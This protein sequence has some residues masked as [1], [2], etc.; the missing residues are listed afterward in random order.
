MELHHRFPRRTD[1][2]DDNDDKLQCALTAIT[3]VA[4]WWLLH[5]GHRKCTNIFIHQLSLKVSKYKVAQI[6]EWYRIVS[7]RSVCT[8]NACTYKHKCNNNGKRYDTLLIDFQFVLC[9]TYVRL[10]S[11]YPRFP[12]SVSFGHILHHALCLLA[13]FSN[14]AD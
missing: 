13:C 14:Q 5:L 6:Q 12:S 10:E 2:A 8:R 3:I 4:L 7:I 9:S 11:P 1:A